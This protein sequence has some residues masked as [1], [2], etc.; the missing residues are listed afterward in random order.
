[1]E[2]QPVD[3]TA[4]DAMSDRLRFE[5][6]VR[7][8]MTAAAP[9]L[10]RRAAGAT[11]IGT[12]STPD[13]ADRLLAAGADH[14]VLYTETDFREEVMRWTAG[15]GATVVYDSVGR[16]TFRASLASLAPR[17]YLV[18]FGQSSGKV[19]PIDPGDLAAGGSLFLT[20]PVLADYIRD[21]AELEWR[22]GDVF[23]AV[24]AGDLAVRIHDVLPLAEASEAHRALEGRRTSGKLLLRT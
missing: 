21:R 4:L 22:A 7:R 19:D 17:G 11:V 23:D 20:R 14:A 18:L 15:A 3:L 24:Q 9:E 5:R 2:E 1:M 10:R 8:V 6:M 12:C 16:T 13:K